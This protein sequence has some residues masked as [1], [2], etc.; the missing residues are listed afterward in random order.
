[1]DNST[2]NLNMNIPNAVNP[3]PN[4]V[5]PIQ[6]AVMTPKGRPFHY[7][8]EYFTRFKKEGKD[9]WSARCRSCAE[10]M[11]GHTDKMILHVKT[12]S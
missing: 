5:N 10:V 11:T 1:M 4:A 6:N 9:Y 12:V 3:I 2:G 8:W 7:V